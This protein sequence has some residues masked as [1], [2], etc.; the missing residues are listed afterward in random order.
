MKIGIF[1]NPPRR[2]SKSPGS[3]WNPWNPL[4]E[5]K[6]SALGNSLGMGTSVLYS[7]YPKTAV[8]DG[9]VA[10]TGLCDGFSTKIDSFNDFSV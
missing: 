9:R 5:G 8:R 4:L 7:K 3:M 2:W 6:A 1:Q 10:D